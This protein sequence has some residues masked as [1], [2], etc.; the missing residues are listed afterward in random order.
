MA[1]CPAS[2]WALSRRELELAKESWRGLPALLTW[3]MRSPSRMRPSL[4]AML[5]GFTCKA[6]ASWGLGPLPKVPVW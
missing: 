3:M 4:A 5:L 2:G 6:R 1:G